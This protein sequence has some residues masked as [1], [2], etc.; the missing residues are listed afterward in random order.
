[1]KNMIKIDSSTPLKAFCDVM[2]N[3]IHF[4]RNVLAKGSLKSFTLH[5]CFKFQSAAHSQK[6][7]LAAGK[8]YDG[9]NKYEILKVTNLLM[10]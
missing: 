3:S 7:F 4:C 8:S 2:Q 10:F 5:C 9:Q 1:M 6:A